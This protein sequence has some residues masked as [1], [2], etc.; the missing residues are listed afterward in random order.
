MELCGM[1]CVNLTRGT[2]KI[3]GVYFSYN[4]NLK[5]DKNFCKHLVKI[6]SS[7]K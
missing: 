5:E 3:L 4:E 2:V 1:E 6:G 7:L